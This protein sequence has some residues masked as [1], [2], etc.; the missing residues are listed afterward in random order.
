MSTP[1]R[2]AP[3]PLGARINLSRFVRDQAE[4][5]ADELGFHWAGVA[6][7]PSTYQ[8]LRGAFEHSKRTGEPL[9]VSNLYCDD[10]VFME[11]RDNV[12]FR[13]WHDTSH[14]RLGLSFSLPDEWELTLWHLAQLEEAGLGPE[15]TEYELL[16]M[17]LLRQVILLGIAQRF[18]F[19]Q[20][21]FTR[22]CGE[23][24]LDAGIL[25]E[26]RRVS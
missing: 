12:A 13:F 5:A 17:D 2:T 3:G 9:A 21:E 23:L 19:N 16:R 18:P 10:T 7:A 20:G 22:T 14:C 25:H 11:P 15:T 1:Y 24:G 6:E 8:Q 4:R 26:L